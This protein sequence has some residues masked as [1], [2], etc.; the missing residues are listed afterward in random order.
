MGAALPR[1]VDCTVLERHGSTQFRVGVAEMNGWRGSM[2]DAHVIHLQNDGG[3]FGILDGHGGA[4]C[5]A[6]CSQRLHETLHSK[7][8]PADDAAAKDMVLTIDQAYLDTGTPSGSTAAMCCIRTP[9]SPGGKYN[10]HVINAG[11]SRVLLSRADG[12][13]ID[14]GGTDGGL[15]TDHKPDHPDERERIYRCG[16]TVEIEMGNVHRVN[17]SL[18]VSRGFG[19][20]DYKQTGGPGLEER[21]VTANP[22][23][24]HF[25]CDGSDFLLLVCDGVSEGNFSNAEVCQ[26]AAKV[27]NETGGDAAAAAEAICFQAVATESKDN[28]SAMIVLLGPA[29]S[30][31][32]IAP[33][34][35]SNFH[36]GC[37]LGIDSSEYKKAYTAM[38]VRGHVTFAEAVEQRYALLVNRRNS[39]AAEATD[40]EEMSLFGNGPQGAMGSAERKS[41]FEDW[42]VNANQE[43]NDDVGGGRGGGGGG[44]AGGAGGGLGG[45][46]GLASQ[47]SGGTPQEQQMM[48][49]MLMNMMQQ[50]QQGGGGKQ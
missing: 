46:G 19:D 15:S 22:E 45:L 11:D 17:G 41:W 44:A 21:P 25:Q 34:K 28:I 38:C 18:A 31:T 24:G 20:A 50:R 5:S 2:E 23:M 3:Y 12:T 10:I 6:W 1:A 8:L 37:L 16:G 9:K 48:M 26:L 29:S 4:Q 49:S 13:M 32:A 27:L 7:G 30:T 14:G 43:D 33:G 36:P 47:L 39:S 42:V 40:E 35:T